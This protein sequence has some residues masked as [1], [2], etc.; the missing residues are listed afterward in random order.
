MLGFGSGLAVFLFGFCWGGLQQAARAARDP[1]PTIS[2]VFYVF[3]RL[4]WGVA[5]IWV[6]V[7]WVWGVVLLGGGCAWLGFG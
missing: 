6:G 1:I 7:G 2:F 5:R 3:V 4:G